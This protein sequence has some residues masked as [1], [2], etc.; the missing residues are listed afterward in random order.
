MNGQSRSFEASYHAF[1][2]YLRAL[3]E[4]NDAMTEAGI[5]AINFDPMANFAEVIVARELNGT[6]QPASNEGF[7]VLSEDGRRV[8]VKSLKVSSAKPDDN[9]LNW[10][11]AT[12]KHGKRDAPLIA[13]DLLA[14]IVYLDSEPYARVLT[15]VVVRDSFPRVHVKDLYFR[16]IEKLRTEPKED[17]QIRVAHLNWMI[18]D[19]D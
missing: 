17:P 6:I 5:T 10:Y 18:S 16:H 15:P 14:V 13:A 12:R 1:N 2:D 3:K 8:Q 9:P 19:V 7:D 4:L 11:S